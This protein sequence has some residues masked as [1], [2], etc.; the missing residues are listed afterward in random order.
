[1]TTIRIVLILTAMSLT[2]ATLSACNTF[3][4]MGQDIQGAG[5]AISGSADETKEKMHR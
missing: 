2:L 5:Q 3:H 4:G 1:M